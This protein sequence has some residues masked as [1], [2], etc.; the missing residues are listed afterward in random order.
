[1]CACRQNNLEKHSL[2]SLNTNN[3]C[4]EDYT[5]RRNTAEMT[6]AP[7]QETHVAAELQVSTRLPASSFILQFVG[8]RL[9]LRYEKHFSS[10]GTCFKPLSLSHYGVD[11]QDAFLVTTTTVIADSREPMICQEQKKKVSLL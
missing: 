9:L 10:R 11:K 1:M 8:L 2:N 5:S 6:L 7:K 4:Q 3:Q